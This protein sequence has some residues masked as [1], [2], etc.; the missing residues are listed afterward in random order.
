MASNGERSPYFWLPNYRSASATG[1]SQQQ[2][3]RTEPHQSSN[4]LTHSPTNSF[5]LTQLNW[6]NSTDCMLIPFPH[7][8][9]R[10]HRSTSSSI[11]SS[12]SRHTDRVENTSSQLVSPLV[13]VR[14]LFCSNGRCLQNHY[15]ASGPHSAISFSQVR[16]SLQF[17]SSLPVFWL[18][19]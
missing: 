8:P 15:L 9:H 19:F 7:G 3:T 11:V 1:F 5:R 4:S 13:H 12:R 10:K 17:T 14:N 18:K 6:T 2:L 16:L